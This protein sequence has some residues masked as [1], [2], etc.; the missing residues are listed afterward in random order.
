MSW[1]ALINRYIATE[2]PRRDDTARMYRG[3]LEN[4]IKPKWGNYA[5][6]DVKPFAVEEWLRT[7]KVLDGSRNLSWKTKKHFRSLMHI[8]YGCAM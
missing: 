3:Y 5:L 2:L 8:L 7:A 1:G 6:N 4:H